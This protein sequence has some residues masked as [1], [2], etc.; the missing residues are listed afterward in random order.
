MNPKRSVL[1]RII[2]ILLIPVGAAFTLSS[3]FLIPVS[4]RPYYYLH[5]FL[6]DIPGKSGYSYEDIKAGYDAVMDFI[7]LGRPFSTGPFPH[8]EEGASHFAD[9]V[10]LFWLVLIVFLVTGAFLLAYL[11]CSKKGWIKPLR[12][13]PFSGIDIGSFALWT[14]VLV[15]G[16]W[17]LVD[18]DGLFVA[19]HHMFFP[20][21]ENW[22]FDGSTDPIIYAL[23]ETFFACCA[24][25]VLTMSLLIGGGFLTHTLITNA[26]RK[27]AHPRPK[28]DPPV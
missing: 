4:F 7:W 13:G 28:Q 23:P 5:C 10:P 12:F 18:F 16:I 6:L 26:K 27:K 8:S 20:G 9:C 11:I 15:V 2:S 25:F 1:D 14:L 22:Q 19:F 21:K 3:S 17:A 24:G